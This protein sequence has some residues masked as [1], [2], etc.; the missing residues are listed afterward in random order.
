MGAIFADLSIEASEKDPS[1]PGVFLKACKPALFAEANLGTYELYSIIARRR[2][3]D[4][5]DIRYWRVLFYTTKMSGR[6]L[7]SRMLPAYVKAAIKKLG[8]AR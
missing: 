2:C 4:I 3:R 6:N 8:I 7:L 5:S 1:M